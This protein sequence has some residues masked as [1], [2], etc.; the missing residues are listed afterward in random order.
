MQLIGGTFVYNKGGLSAALGRATQQ[1]EMSVI[2]KVNS[3][4]KNMGIENLKED[5]VNMDEKELKKEEVIVAEIPKEKMAVEEKPKEESTE[6]EKKEQIK[7]KENKKE[8]SQEEKKEEEEEKKEKMSL[9]ANLDVKAILAMLE[10]ETENF[11]AIAEGEFDKPEG[12][13]NFSVV[14]SAMFAKMCKMAEEAK[15]YMAKNVELE[16]FKSKIEKAEFK[17]A[18]DLSL[19]ELEANVEI[20]TKELEAM[21]E[22]SEKFT[23]ETLDAWKNDCKAQAFPFAVK[24]KK[25]NDG[26]IKIGL[27]WMKT[28]D[29]SESVWE[30]L[31][32]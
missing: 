12:E 3:I 14:C 31:N 20:P 24:G 29:K 27:P 8:S 11:K 23:I 9:D 7:E 18:V 17:M 4:R 2:N 13:K 15:A 21:R 26:V 25:G 16:A 5:N 6:E 30:K 10:D 19:K 32:K 22:N 28:S 1:N